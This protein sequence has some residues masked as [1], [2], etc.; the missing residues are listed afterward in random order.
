MNGIYRG[1]IALATVLPLTLPFAY[2][3]SGSVLDFL[4]E[5]VYWTFSRTTWDAILMAVVAGGNYSAGKAI[6][7]LLR[8]YAK[9]V[10]PEPISVNAVRGMGDDSLLAYLPYVLPFF[11]VQ[12][13]SQNWVGWAFGIVMLWGLAWA[14]MTIPF[15]P[16]LRICGLRYYEAELKDGT[17][18]TLLIE[19]RKIRPLRLKSV[20]FV[21]EFCKYGVE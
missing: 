8:R 13:E 11:V 19:G 18:V 7:W 5:A 17:T 1:L 9:T 20:V 10:S 6:L 15:S 3:F 12:P 2:M 21:T 16:L 4:P 14:A